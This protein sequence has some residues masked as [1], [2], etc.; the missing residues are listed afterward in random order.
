MQKKEIRRIAVPV[1]AGQKVSKKTLSQ[2]ECCGYT[3]NV[4]CIGG[5]VRKIIFSGQPHAYLKITKS[6]KGLVCVY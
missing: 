4:S 1:Q 3:C 2:A 5:I 6:Q